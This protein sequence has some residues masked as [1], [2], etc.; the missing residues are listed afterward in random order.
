MSTSYTANIGLGIPAVSDR[1]WNLPLSADLDLLDVLAPIG[2]LCVQEKEHPS[3]TLNVKVAAGKFRKADGT[4]GTYAG[5]SSQ[6]ITTATTKVLYLDNSGTLTVATSYPASSHVR[7]ATVVAG[8]TTITSVTD[9]RIV[10][11][12]LGND[13]FAYLPLAGGT[14][15]NGASIAVGTTTGTKIGTTTSQKIGFYNAT[16]VVQAANTTDLR[17][18]LIDIG[19]LATGGASP[20]DLNGGAFTAA[21]IATGSI[22]MTDATNIAVGTST[23]TKIGTATSQKIGFYNATP[24]VQ[25]SG[26][27][28]AAVSQTQTTLTDST[29][30]TPSTTLAAITAGTLYAQADMTAAKDAIASLAAELAFVAADVAATQTLVNKLR[31]DLVALGLIKGS[32]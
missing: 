31:T 32:A 18:V 11:G 16:P 24:D 25:P 15:V 27:S 4:V 3:T 20:L 14:L 9:D 6:A 22:T 1:N 5:T 17:T 30:G 29:G 8:A 10:N 21:S 7:L 2:G 19:L 13:A 23:G 12:V 28:Q 26:A